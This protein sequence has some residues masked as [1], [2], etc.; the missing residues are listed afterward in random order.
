MIDQEI[1][2]AIAKAKGYKE[3]TCMCCSAVDQ[4]DGA[5]SVTKD[6]VSYCLNYTND[7]AL[8]LEN[9]IELGKAGYHYLY[10]R[11]LKKHFWF[12]MLV[13]TDYYGMNNH[14]GKATALA[15]CKMRGIKV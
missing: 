8:I 9:V 12:K 13:S 3:T 5:V 6:G 4:F 7:P 11:N 1:N 14:F 15:Y 10:N 2:L